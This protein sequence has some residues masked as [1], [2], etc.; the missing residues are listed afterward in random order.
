MI[1]AQKS[2]KAA[3]IIIL[4]NFFYLPVKLM[5]LDMLSSSICSSPDITIAYAT[6]QSMTVRGT[7]RQDKVFFFIILLFWP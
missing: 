6:Q 3:K 2:A 5:K 7:C 4:L 1:E